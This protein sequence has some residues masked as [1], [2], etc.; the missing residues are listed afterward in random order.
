MSVVYVST[1]D[2]WLSGPQAYIWPLGLSRLGNDC[3][4]RVLSERCAF[5]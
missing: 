5:Y 4:I 2:P 1:K 3:L